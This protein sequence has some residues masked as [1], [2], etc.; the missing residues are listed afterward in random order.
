MNYWEGPDGPRNIIL[1]WLHDHEDELSDGFEK[2]LLMIRDGGTEKSLTQQLGD[3]YRR[4]MAAIAD[5]LVVRLRQE[6]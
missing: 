1:K 3:A 2:H 4:E 6:R 5:D